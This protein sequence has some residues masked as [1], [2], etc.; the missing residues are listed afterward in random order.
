MHSTPFFPP[1]NPGRTGHCDE[2]ILSIIFA[3]LIVCLM[4]PSGG[5][6]GGAPRALEGRALRLWLV[7]R[8]PLHGP[9]RTTPRT[10]EYN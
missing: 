2:Y 10:P 3:Q 8:G 9:E 4:R 1:D 6:P 5:P 7:M